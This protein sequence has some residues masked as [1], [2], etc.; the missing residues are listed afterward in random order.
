MQAKQDTKKARRIASE[1]LK[2]DL[3]AI[4]NN[5]KKEHR[6]YIS[7]PR[8]E[9]HKEIHLLGQVLVNISIVFVYGCTPLAVPSGRSDGIPN[10]WTGFAVSEL[11]EQFPQH[12]LC[13]WNQNGRQYASK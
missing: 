13:T 4:A 9:E 8:D 6:I 3:E 5:I 1:T 10:M 7:L 12:R 2:E 11:S